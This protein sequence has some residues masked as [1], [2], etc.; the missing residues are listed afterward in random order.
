MSLLIAAWAINR[1]STMGYPRPSTMGYLIQSTMGYLRPSTMGYLRPSTMSLSHI[2]GCLSVEP[3]NETRCHPRRSVHYR[4][5]WCQRSLPKVLS[6]ISISSPT[7]ILP[8]P[9]YPLPYYLLPHCPPPTLHCFW[10]HFIQSNRSS[11]HWWKS[12]VFVHYLMN[13]H[14]SKSACRNSLS[15]SLIAFNCLPKRINIR[16]GFKRSL[17]PPSLGEFV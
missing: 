8:L 16:R 3:Q 15:F 7:H 12:S 10:L 6:H 1:P 2:T 9:Y 11:V 5:C 13:R 4:I 14:I 17:S